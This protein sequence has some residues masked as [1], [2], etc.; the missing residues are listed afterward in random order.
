MNAVSRSLLA[1]TLVAAAVAGHA[2]T[3]DDGTAQANDALTLVARI[4]V[5]NMTGTWDHLTVDSVSKRLF[6]SAQEDNQ[7]RAFDLEARK[8]L[9]TISGGSNPPQGLSYVPST[10]ALAVT[11]VTAGSLRTFNV[12]T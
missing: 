2:Q 9:Y 8:P 6:A 1:V 10:Q 3:L 5:P 11:N 7:V 12:K 4:P